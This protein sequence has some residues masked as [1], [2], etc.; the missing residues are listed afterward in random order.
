M[1]KI[2]SITSQMWEQLLQFIYRGKVKVTADEKDALLTASTT[3]GLSEL[4]VQ[5]VLSH[6]VKISKKYNHPPPDLPKNI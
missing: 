2:P 6:P 1:V 5:Q 3:L 4:Q